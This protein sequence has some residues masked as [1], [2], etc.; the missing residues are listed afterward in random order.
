MTTHCC[1][2]LPQSAENSILNCCKD[3]RESADRENA[4]SCFLHNRASQHYSI[5]NLFTET[6]SPDCF[7]KR[8][9]CFES[10]KL[11]RDSRTG[12]LNWKILSSSTLCFLESKLEGVLKVLFT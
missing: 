2:G 12:F 6:L 3:P 10:V 8:F 11:N 9:L 5:S 1:V 7:N 4:D